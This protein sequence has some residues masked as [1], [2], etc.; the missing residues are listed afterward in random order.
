MG[1]MTKKSDLWFPLY[2]GLGCPAEAPQALL[3]LAAM[4]D[5]IIKPEPSEI[6]RAEIAKAFPEKRFVWLTQEHTHIVL[7][8]DYGEMPTGRL[9]DGLVTNDAETVIGVTVADCLPVFLWDE[10]TGARALCHSGW[11]GTGIVRE[12][13]KLM[14]TRYGASPATIRAILGPCIQ[15]CCYAV[16]RE[17]AETFAAKFGSETGF[18]RDGK[19]YM[20]LA[21]A[22]KKILSDEGVKAIHM[23]GECTCCDTRFSSYRRQ[24]DSFTL[25][26]ALC[27]V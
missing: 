24:G 19:W 16:D 2:W 22:N 6:V 4:G 21:A 25:M 3:S 12:A 7:S 10:V 17:R 23:H 27:D 13:L 20:N 5:M 11:K 14:K 15:S 26:L 18:L 1:D 9:G 8:A